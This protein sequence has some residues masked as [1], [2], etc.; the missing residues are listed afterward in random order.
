M[1]CKFNGFAGAFSFR[2]RIFSISLALGLKE[3]V[4][5]REYLY[6]HPRIFIAQSSVEQLV[7]TVCGGVDAV[8]VTFVSASV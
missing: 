1:G 5:P 4:K 7:A 3:F 2:R 8:G 6:F